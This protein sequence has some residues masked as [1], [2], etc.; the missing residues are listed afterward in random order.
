MVAALPRQLTTGTGT[1]RFS[2]LLFG[3]TL[4]NVIVRVLGFGASMTG[5]DEGPEE[6]ISQEVCVMTLVRRSSPLGE[7]V[8]LR[9]AMDRLFEDSFVRPRSWAFGSFDG[10]GVPVDV[11]NGSDSFMVEASLPGFKPE[12]VDITVENGVLS[13]DAEMRSE[14]QEGEGETLV[15]EIRRG[16][17]SRTI[18]LPTGIEPDK[19]T[20]SFEDGV[21]KLQIP[22]VEA[23][24]PRQI[25]ISPTTNA[26]TNGSNGEQGLASG[27]T[28]TETA[29][30]TV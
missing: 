6:P 4:D 28:T 3:N 18:T 19:A 5:P 10:Y 29:R 25:R 30:A 14:R 13:I 22:K 17:V 21:L 7:L 9:Q 26:G 1:P 16:R 15:Q 20:A 23:V 27:E 2:I 8:S 24:K 12:D 11:T